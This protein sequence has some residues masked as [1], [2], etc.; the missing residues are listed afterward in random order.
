MKNETKAPVEMREGRDMRI[1]ALDIGGTRLKYGMFTLG[2]TGEL[3][4]C[5]DGEVDSFAKE[6]ASALMAQ[7]FS[8]C[9]AQDFDLLGVSSAGMIGRDGS[10]VYANENIPEYTGYPLSRVLTERYGVP[11]YAQNDIASGAIAEATK[12]RRDFY[13]L[14]LGTGVGGI[15]VKDG[16]PL[17]G[18][19]GIAGQIGYLP[20]LD[21][22]DCIDRAASTSA[23]CRRGGDARA[24]FDA[25]S[26]GDDT[27]KEILS[28]WAREV[29]HVLSLIVGFYDPACIVIGGGISRQGERLLSALLREEEVLPLPY[30]G[31]FRLEVAARGGRSGVLGAA[32]YALRRWN[33][34]SGR[35]DV[36]GKK[37]P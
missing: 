32:V 1:F 33:E 24:L 37:M 21:G 11:V 18:E 3:V 7:V 23:L 5:S 28:A 31:K 36:R 4:E 34:E 10:V 27:A 26:T 9:D 25:A 14:S 30:R 2:E 19:N 35:S 13:Y 17:V 20:S 16:M 22:T 15:M 29:M 8:V 12:A 6:G